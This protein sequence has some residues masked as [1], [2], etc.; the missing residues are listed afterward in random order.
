MAVLYSDA[1]IVQSVSHRTS[2]V[3][4]E[5]L[6]L[7]QAVCLCFHNQMSP[8]SISAPKSKIKFITTLTALMRHCPHDVK[9]GVITTQIYQI[10]SKYTFTNASI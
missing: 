3:A 6:M 8:T 7:S 10:W 4:V 5:D 9:M 2:L 1:I